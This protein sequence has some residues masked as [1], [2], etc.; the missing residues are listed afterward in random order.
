M[1]ATGSV[2][3]KRKKKAEVEER[4]PRYADVDDDTIR[5]AVHVPLSEVIVPRMCSTCASECDASVRGCCV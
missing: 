5:Q 4:L 3:F 2:G 1:G